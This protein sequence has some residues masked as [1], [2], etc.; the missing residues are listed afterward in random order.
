MFY[1]YIRARLTA[2]GN[3][4]RQI[5]HVLLAGAC[6]FQPILLGDCVGE[7]FPIQKF[8]DFFFF[9]VRKRLGVLSQ[10]LHLYKHEVTF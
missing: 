3:L 8:F 7:L 10:Q 2:D 5:L 6:A 1:S 4:I 9:A